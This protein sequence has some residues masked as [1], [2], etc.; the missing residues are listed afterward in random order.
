RFDD[1]FDYEHEHE[2]E[3]TTIGKRSNPAQGRRQRE[4][5]ETVSAYMVVQAHAMNRGVTRTGGPLLAGDPC[6]FGP[7]RHAYEIAFEGGLDYARATAG[8]PELTREG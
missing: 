4:T 1:W 8:E 6:R 7:K 2:H 3:R 5:V